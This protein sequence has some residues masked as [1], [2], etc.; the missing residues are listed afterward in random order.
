M[1]IGVLI[2]GKSGSGKSAALRNCTND[3]VGVISVLGKPFPFKSD[4]KAYVTD[5]YDKV[6]RA[7]INSKRKSIVIDDSGYLITNMFMKGHSQAGKGN[8]VFSFYNS[9]GDKFWNLI[10]G[11]THGWQRDKERIYLSDNKIVYFL[12]HEEKNDFGDVK[13]KTI[14]KL[15]D[16][17]VNIEG[18]F[19]IVFR[20]SVENQT[21]VF[22]TKTQGFDVAKT[23]MGMFEEVTIDNDIAMIDKTIREYYNLGVIQDEKA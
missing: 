22:H 23:P 9:V 16:E 13:P 5:D 18:L 21:H 14:G 6:T 4:L 10:H 3:D 7:L 8:E 19:S 1:A 11:L 17:K 15:L 2:I 12:M 20:A